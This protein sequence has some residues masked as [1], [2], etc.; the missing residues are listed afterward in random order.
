MFKVLLIAPPVIDFYNTPARM[1]PLGLLYLKEALREV[2][3][4]SVEIFDAFS[5]KRAKKRTWPASFSHLERFYCEDKSDF[6]LFSSYYRFGH[7]VGKIVEKVDAER[8]DLIGISSL[9]SAY[10]PDVEEII[11]AIKGRTS[12]P[13]VVGGWAVKAEPEALF[14]KSRADFF[15]AGGES[16]FAQLVTH[17]KEERPLDE[18]PDLLFRRN[19]AVLRGNGRV[20]RP[21]SFERPPGRE[22]GY[23]FKGMPM[24][25]VTTSRG[26]RFR[27][28]FCLVH[29]FEPFVVRSLPSIER[30]LGALFE[31]GVRLVDFEDDNLF[32]EPAWS[33]AFLRILSQFEHRGMRFTAMNGM[34]AANLAPIIDEV[35]KAGF[36]E[37]NISLV[38]SNR[39]T[40][41][42]LKRPVYWEHVETIAQAGMGK[43]DTLV[44]LILG[45]PGATCSGTVADIGKL[46]ALPVKV[47]V[48]PLYMLPGIEMFEEMGLPD[49]RRLLRGSALYR[50]GEDFARED[51]VSMWKLA[52]MINH[53]K[54]DPTPDE[55]LYYFAKSVVEGIWHAKSRDGTWRRTFPFST[56]LPHR[57]VITDPLGTRRDYDLRAVVKRFEPGSGPVG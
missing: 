13:V 29:R 5:S 16:G 43:V 30:E 54:D 37:I 26:C 56:P 53:L 15:L 25:R 45:L 50:F 49:D 1:E 35:I 55:D 17:L 14:G 6:S 8:F 4:V 33:R 19:G 9:F 46:A 51:I 11:G 57:L 2:P 22:G 40:A 7:G 3:Q 48:S 36:I 41:R 39:D 23:R 24:A 42:A 31:Q 18:V 21:F 32:F 27:C 47:G 44:F 10:H 28:K 38:S 12:A 20:Q 52:R 34:T